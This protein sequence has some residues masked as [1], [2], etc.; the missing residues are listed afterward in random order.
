MPAVQE[1]ESFDYIV[2]GAGSAG[3]VVAARLS[4]DP[5]V[6]VLLVEAGGK[7]HHPYLKMPL[8][9]LK[10]VVDPRFNWPYLTESEP[11]LGGRRLPLPRGRVLGGCSSINGMFAMR[12]HPGDYDEWARM[13]ATGWSYA[14]VL[15][16]FRKLEDSWRGESLYH[17]AGGPV[18]IRPISSPLLLHEP[19]MATATAAGFTHSEDL[20]GERAEGFARGEMTIDGRGRRVSAA[21]A[22]LGPA[23]SRPNLVVRTG[24]LVRR[25]VIEDGQATGIEIEHPDGP[26]RIA[27]RREVVISGGTYNS[28]H[29][30]MLSGIGPAEQLRAHGIRV[31]HDSPGVGENLAEHA[32]VSMEW[33][34]ARP[35]TFINQLRWD[36]L[37]FNA[38]RWAVTG[39]GPLALQLNSCNVVIRTRDHLDRPDIQFMANPIRFDAHPWFPGLTRRQSHVFWAGLVALHPA[40]RGHVRLR[41]SDP[42]DVPAVTLNLMAEEADLATMRAGMR[43]ARKIYGTAPQADLVTGERLPGTAVTEDADFDAFIRETCYVAMH[44]TGTCAMAMGDRSVL[45]PQL[46]VIGVERLRVADC[47]VMPRIPGG[48]TNLP[49]IMVGEKCADLMRG[50]AL[51]PAQ[52]AAERD[53][54]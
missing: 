44:P 25:V 7:A 23:L 11:H 9:F 18:Q 39:G 42:R 38:L 17:G 5:S 1:T 16:Y 53:A 21:T 4:E 37:A 24:V 49:A 51:A 50:K 27:A 12:G 13:G 48:N 34:A 6:S 45:D 26:R 40:S 15:P 36:R 52:L 31:V 35:V 22:Y 30:L 14:D 19:L 41:S 28:P 33:D 32:N 29:L 20:A 43:A 2:V 46:R 10:A 3:C 54:A 8:A 47:S